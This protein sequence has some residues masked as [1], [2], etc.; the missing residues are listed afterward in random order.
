MQ[1][2]DAKVIYNNKQKGSDT[3]QQVDTQNLATQNL[4]KN[5]RDKKSN[6]NRNLRGSKG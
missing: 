4:V 5:L 6:R 1:V 3:P 2:P